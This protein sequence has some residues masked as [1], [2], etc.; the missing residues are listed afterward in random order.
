[1]RIVRRSIS[2][3]AIVPSAI[4]YTTKNTP[5]TTPWTGSWAAAMATMAVD[6]QLVLEGPAPRL[7]DEWQLA[8]DDVGPLVCH[9]RLRERRVAAFPLQRAGARVDER[10]IPA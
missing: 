3:W 4:W 10:E 2:R 8:A 1:M 7:V 5:A 9:R 6:P